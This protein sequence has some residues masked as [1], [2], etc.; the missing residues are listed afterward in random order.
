MA[1]SGYHAFISYSHSADGAFAPALQRALQHFG[2]SWRQRRAMEVFRDET[3]LAVDPNL[4]GAITSALDSSEWFVLLASPHAA[5]SH[6]VGQEIQHCIA[7]KG[8]DRI[9]IVLTEGTLRW[10]DSTGD[11]SSDSDAVHPALRGLLT[12]APKIVDLSWTRQ[13]TDLT[14]DNPRFRADIARLVALIRDEPLPQ[15]AEQDARERR[16][17]KT[18]TRTALGALAT[19]TAVAVVAAITAGVNWQTAAAEQ[20]TAEEQAQVALARE[21]AAKSRATED[22]RAALALSVEAYSGAPDRESAGSLL[23]AITGTGS[24][25]VEL[26]ALLPDGYLPADI[27]SSSRSEEDGDRMT[28]STAAG[29]VA[30]DLTAG[31]E[32]ALPGR[33]HYLT[34]DGSHAIGVDGRVFALDDGGAVELVGTIPALG[35]E[36][37]FTANGD[38]FA[39]RNDGAGGAQLVVADVAGD[40]VH[41]VP[42]SSGEDCAGCSGDASSVAIAPDGSMVAARIGPV[43]SETPIRARLTIYSTD[44]SGLTELATT[45]LGGVGSVRFTDD[46]TAVWA[47]DD[48]EVLV[49][50]PDTLEPA[51][52]AMS[53]ARA[54]P[55]RYATD[56]LALAPAD[57]CMLP[58]VVLAPTMAT[59][60]D[61][62]A[63]LTYAESGCYDT[64]A[65][66][67]EPRWL[68]DGSWVRTSAGVWPTDTDQLLALACEALGGAVSRDEFR[69]FSAVDHT[70]AGCAE[71]GKE[72]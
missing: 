52:E 42:V 53:I 31:T 36:P 19:A 14:L 48:G 47:R 65:P 9:L 64:A 1:H 2:R 50:A 4:W 58:G 27:R 66:G 41:S 34:P 54:G 40:E 68:F 43:W 21:F 8:S 18:V 35:T 72:S 45:E 56:A 16:R 12:S 62:P 51:G 38:R 63:D 57:G 67:G 33:T 22:P 49:L 5:A 59:I 29:S 70:P 11:F 39:Y 44:G 20:A 7:T 26:P 17:T 24:E 71:F 6:W 25:L 37:S 32:W 69:E 46:G 13:E 15:V 23:A 55:L 3:G 61:L 60:A 28:L 30:L 10:D